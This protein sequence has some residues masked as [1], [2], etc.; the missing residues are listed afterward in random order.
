MGDACWIAGWGARS[1]TNQKRSKALFQGGVNLLSNEY[2][3]AHASN[4]KATA[5]LT[6]KQVYT[7][8]LKDDELCG[9]TPDLNKNGLT[10]RGVDACQGDSGGP[11]ICNVGGFATLQGVVTWGVGCAAEGSPGV[12][13]DV[14]HFRN[15]IDEQTTPE[16]SYSSSYDEY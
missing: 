10:D 13:A 2:C 9:G 3:K 5:R 7:M 15:W 8:L 14:H 4:E 12:F 16:Y 6:I 1:S 11:L